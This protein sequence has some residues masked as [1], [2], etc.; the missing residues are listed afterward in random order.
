MLNFTPMVLLPPLLQ[1]HMN[2][3]D[4]LVGQVIGCRGAGMMVGFLSAGLMSRID[5]RFGLAFGFLIQTLSGVWMLTFDLNVTWEILVLTSLVQGFAVGVIWVPLSVIAF[6]TLAPQHRAEASAVFH[7]LRNMG[8]SFFISLS[9]AEIVRATGA[10]YSRMTEM[11]T[12]Y[13]PALQMPWATGGWTFDTVSG[14]AKVSGEITRQ[15]AMIGY[16]NAFMM[17]TVASGLAMAFILLVR[18]RRAAVAPPA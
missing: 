6:D 2:F 13:N 18:R 11:V 4:A 7:L 12:P 16:L 9:I 10:N 15:S 14:L 1:Q 8:S 3:S 5:P 17:Y